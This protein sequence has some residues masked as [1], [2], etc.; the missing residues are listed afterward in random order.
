VQT[1]LSYVT[2][3]RNSFGMAIQLG[4]NAYL[5]GVLS[6]PIAS[7]IVGFGAKVLINVVDAAP[8]VTFNDLHAT[9]GSGAPHVV[10]V[11]VYF[12]P[13][14][15][16]IRVYRGSSSGV[17]LASTGNNVFTNNTWNYVEVFVTISTTAGVVR[18]NLN[19]TQVL[20]ATGLNTQASDN[21]WFEAVQFNGAPAPT[22]TNFQID[23]FYLANPA[24]TGSGAVAFNDF[25]GDARVWTLYATADSGTQQWTPLTA[26]PNWQQVAETRNDGDTTYNATLTVGARDNFLFQQL[27]TTVQVLAVQVTGSYRRD[28]AGPRTIDQHLISPASG[29]TDVTGANYLLPNTYVYCNDFWTIDPHTSA[30]WTVPAVNAAAAG[31]ALVS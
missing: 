31:Y 11:S 28:D 3:G 17:L 13:I 9:T 19:S 29:G 23:D 12:D 21:A 5:G 20:N 26:T 25:I 15:G 27:P 10:Q 30:A 4:Q 7:G 22:A 8:A 1:G 16:A 18:V 24:T 14:T 2:P 6:T